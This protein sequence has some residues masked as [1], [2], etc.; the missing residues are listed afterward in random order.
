ML[1]I[2]FPLL[3]EKRKG[4]DLDPLIKII[5]EKKIDRRINFIYN[6]IPKNNCQQCAKCCFSCAEVYFIEFINITRFLKSLP[7]D[8][9]QKIIKNCINYEFLN[10]AT[11]DYSCPFLDDVECTIHSVRPIHSRMF[12]IYPE[13]DYKAMLEAS[14]NENNEI[15]K[16]FSTN[17]D[18]KLP[19]KVMTHDVKQCNNNEN[20]DG[21]L[22]ALSEFERNRLHRQIVDIQ[23][24][25][26]PEDAIPDFPRARYSYYFALCYFTM[27]ELNNMQVQAI[28]EFLDS[29]K[30]FTADEAIRSI[31]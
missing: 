3:S 10:L 30:S 22:I 16:M 6:Q 1:E 19:E 24:N 5:E 23:N 27:D 31:I 25:T 4:F 11:L 15:S 2:D 18:I 26:I 9:Q 21:E 13:S 12:G 14:Q 8:I 7:E 29:G 20:N 28:R 17:Y